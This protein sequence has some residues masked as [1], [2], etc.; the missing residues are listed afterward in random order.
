LATL[1]YLGLVVFIGLKL[2][3]FDGPGVVVFTG[4]EHWNENGVT[5]IELM[6]GV[7]GTKLS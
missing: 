7:N 3:V 2:V 5:T 1:S 4:P 6:S